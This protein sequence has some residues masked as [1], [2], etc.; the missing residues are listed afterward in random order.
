M[1]R[2]TSAILCSLAFATLAQANLITNGS[3]EI[4]VVTSSSEFRT[5]VPGSEPSGFGWQ[6]TK[7]N[8]D[9]V[10]RGPIFA[11]TAFDGLQ[12]LDLDGTVPGGIA[13]SFVTTPGNPYVLTF[14]YANN[15]HPEAG[16][17]VPAH[18]TVSIFDTASTSDLITPLLLTHGSSTVVAPDWITSGAITFVAQGINT[19][20]AF[21][22]NDP[23]GSGGIFLDAVSV[24]GTPQVPEPATFVL[25]SIGLAGMCFGKRR[26]LA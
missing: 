18:G 20:L 4:P 14:A 7:G 22:S 17:T 12:F 1:F 21:T 15:P 2:Y 24:N 26:K 13:Q 10:I 5:I 25:M 16:A 3:F 8:V 19:T 9:T 23:S 6:I 11:S